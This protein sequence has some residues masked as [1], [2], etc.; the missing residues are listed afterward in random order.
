MGLTANHYI[1]ARKI[2]MFRKFK[3]LF[4]IVVISLGLQAQ[5]GDVRG[6]VYDKENGEPVIFTNVI[7]KE[8]RTGKT[9]D[10]DGFYTITRLKPGNYT[11]ILFSIEYDTLEINIEIKAGRIT[12]QNLYPHKRRNELR[13]VSIRGDRQKV[14]ENVNVSTNVITQKELSKLPTFGGEPDLVQYLQVL[15]GVN[16]SGD[17][18]GQLYIRGGPPVM[19][20]VLM[21]G[22]IVYNPFHSIG[23]FSVFDAD[24]IRNAEVSAGGFNAQYGGRVSGIIDV[25]TREG[26]KK[27]FA[28][29]VSINPITAKILFEGPISPFSEGNGSSSYI[30]SY[31]TSYLDKTSKM[32]YE[33]ADKVNGLPYTFED[34]YGKF[35]YIGPNGSKL[36]LFGFNFNDNALFNSIKYKWDSYGFGGNLN[37]IPEE[38]STIINGNLGYS[39][40]NISE[41]PDAVHYRKSYVNSF[42]A[43]VGFTYYIG[44]DDIKYGFDIIGLT[45]GFEYLPLS[46]LIIRD[47]N[48]STEISG[49]AKYKKVVG[50]FV[51]EPGIRVINYS[52]LSE[53]SLEPRLGVKYNIRSWLRLKMAGGFYSQNL[54]SAVSD[55]DVVNL[56]YGFLSSIEKDQMPDKLGNQN[57]SYSRQTSEH[58]A[59]GIEVDVI[60]N[61]S[62]NVEGF[63][64]NFSQ[65]T[66]VNRD[67]TYD[68]SN[69][70]DKYLSSKGFTQLEIERLTSNFIAENGGAY[71]GDATLKYEN[72][73]IYLWAVYSL[74]FVDRY[75][76]VRNYF[77][78]FD[79]RHNLNIVGNY[80]W[81]T[82]KS[83]TMNLRWNIASGFPFTQIKGFYEQLSFD[84]GVSSDYKNLNG[85]LGIF[86]EDINTGRLPAFHRLDISVSK[87]IKLD[88][89]SAL[90]IT[91]AATNVYNR[92]NIFYI[93]PVNNKRINQLPLMPTLGINFSF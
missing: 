42:N 28:G 29:K 22:M 2:C 46:D 69:E 6:H 48:N 82:A 50:R 12:T 9:T 57:I 92:A 81:G 63:Y 89:S 40:Y 85:S 52:A 32:F 54:V 10:I 26:N 56:F 18:G 23:L 8:L 38:S 72:K 58:I 62:L 24:I 51:I 83:W 11:L 39:S 3:V 33:S 27:E 87:K 43:S 20:K 53:T 68:Y 45:T 65:I 77:P 71:G 59:L 60:R 4:F 35:S 16:F 61:L 78:H 75:D 19:N 76:G 86:Y 41:Q 7:V 47:D 13:E 15:P 80:S 73:N 90:T 67:K 21:D 34:L 44:K 37:I 88:K 55:Q 64:K 25:T 5:T 93:D 84:N 70:L 74:T 79:R 1:R 30:V 14:K 17:Q 66:N 49:F 36:N 91:A 31:K